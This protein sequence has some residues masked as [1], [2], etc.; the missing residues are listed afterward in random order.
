MHPS[1]RRIPWYSFLRREERF[2]SFGNAETV[3][4]DEEWTAR[5]DQ[6]RFQATFGRAPVSVSTRAGFPTRTIG[7]GAHGFYARPLLLRVPEGELLVEVSI[8]GSST[9]SVEIVMSA[10]DADDALDEDVYFARGGARFA[11]V[12]VPMPS[13]GSLQPRSPGPIRT[14]GEMR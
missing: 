10:A 7:F 2:L 11:A 14:P 13:E 1:R 3:Y 8:L 9:R 6:G 5:F 12:E 4:E